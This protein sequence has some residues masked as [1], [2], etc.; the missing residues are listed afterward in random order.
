M[1]RSHPHRLVLVRRFHDEKAAQHL[2]GFGIGLIGQ[3]RFAATRAQGKRSL[4]TIKR[5]AD[6]HPTGFLQLN[7]FGGRH[8]G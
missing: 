2:L 1:Q 3:L 4:R 8:G 5:D 7:V 6:H